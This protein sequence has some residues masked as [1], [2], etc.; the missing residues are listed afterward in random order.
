MLVHLILEPVFSPMNNS[1]RLELYD[2]DGTLTTIDIL[3]ALDGRGGKEV[4]EYVVAA[5]E[6]VAKKTGIPLGEVFDGIKAEIIGIFPNRLEE[7]YWAV[8][9][10]SDKSP[11]RIFPAEDHFILVQAGARKFLQ[12]RLE[13]DGRESESGRKIAGFLESSW[14]NPMYQHANAVSM[15]YAEMDEDAIHAVEKRIRAGALAAVISN[16]STEK[17][18]KLLRKAGFGDY[19]IQDRVEPGRIGAIGN[20]KKWLVDVSVPETDENILDLR[21]FGLP[22]LLDLRRKYFQDRVM[23]LMES[24]GAKRVLMATDIP[25]L[26]SFPLEIALPRGSVSHGIKLNPTGTLQSMNA[27]RTLLGARIST[28]FSELV[29]GL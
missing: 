10:A 2:L 14:I 8:F 7:Q 12:E 29:D 3:S 24:V 23:A 11:K 1:K 17:V 28:R 25:A 19:L 13:E 5:S 21:S 9:P 16:S 18:D 4:L 15:E 6:F 27:A 22:V 26:D 20:A